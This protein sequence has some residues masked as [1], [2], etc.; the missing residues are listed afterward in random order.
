MI[1]NQPLV[2]GGNGQKLTEDAITAYSWQKFLTSG[3][4]R[5]P[6]RLPMTKSVVRAMDTI[7]SFC[8]SPAGGGLVIA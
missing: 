5:W 3:D 1:P 7:T 8:A 4:E 2:F 6:L